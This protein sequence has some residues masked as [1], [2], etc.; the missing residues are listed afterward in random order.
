[1]SCLAALGS[2]AEIRICSVEKG[3]PTHGIPHG[4]LA[5][6]YYSLA[7]ISGRA[8]EI[9]DLALTHVQLAI[10]LNRDDFA[11]HIAVRAS[12][13]LQMGR[14]DAA[15]TDYRR[16][17]ELRKDRGG[18]AYG[19]AL[20]QCGYALLKT[21]QKQR[22]VTQME[23]GL[24]LLKSGQP[25]GFQVR[26]M[27]KLAE[28]YA[29][30]WKFSAALDLDAEAYDLALTIGAHDQIHTVERLARRLRGQPSG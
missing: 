9:L 28:G 8:N 30:S 16:V 4:P 5:S 13:L 11:N 19:E 24:E 1:M 10:E 25:S 3:D 23:E 26:A 14:P 6:V 7:K 21:G 29:R 15:L 12:I 20:S 27:R 22:G 18:T 17:V 2:L